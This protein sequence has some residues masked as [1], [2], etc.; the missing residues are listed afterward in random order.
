MCRRGECSLLLRISGCWGE[1]VSAP[2]H[3]EQLP[4]EDM[5]GKQHQKERALQY[6]GVKECGCLE[7][8]KWYAVHIVE[9]VGGGCG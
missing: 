5:T 7:H 9:G 1:V 6:M 4:R 8:R 2:S 3:F